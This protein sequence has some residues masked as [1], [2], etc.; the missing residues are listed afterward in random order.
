MQWPHARFRSVIIIF[1]VY[2]LFIMAVHAPFD[3]TITAN[4]TTLN[5]NTG[6]SSTSTITLTGSGGSGNV[7]LN[8][9]VSPAGL[10]CSVIP[11]TVTLGTTATATLVC[12][13]TM[14]GTFTVIVTGTSGTLSH[15]AVVTVNVQDFAITSNPSTLNP[16]VG[17]RATS[18]ISITGIN[19]FA[20]TVSL[21]VGTS[22]AGSSCSVSPAAVTLPPSPSTTTLSCTASTA[23]NYT[24]AV[25]GTSGSLSHTTSLTLRVSDFAI[26][27]GP[28][29]VTVNSG[30]TGTATVVLTSQNGYAGTVGLTVS[31]SPAGL[32]CFL[33]PSSLTLTM[34]ATSRLDCGGLVGTYTVTV[35]GSSGTLTHSAT[36]TYTVQDFTLGGS[37]ALTMNA[38]TAVTSPIVLDSVNGFTGTVTLSS[39]VS[40]A[41]G[42]TCSLAPST[43]L[44]GASATSSLSCTGS[45][46]VYTVTVTG[47]SN[48]L[49]HAITLTY[50]VEDMLVVPATNRVTVA[51][52]GSGITTII[53]VG[54]DGFSG[55][56]SLTTNISPNT[57]LTCSL[58]PTSIIL[59]NF[60]TST[61]S[62]AGD[63]GTYTV[64]VTATSGSLSHTTRLTYTVQGPTSSSSSLSL[65]YF[66]VAAALAGSGLTGTFAVRR[67]NKTTAPFDEFFNLTG[68]E[69]QP[70]AT[71]LITGDPGAGTTTLGLQLLHRQLAGGKY[72]G[73]LTYDAFPS[74][75]QLK[76]RSL[77]LDVTGSLKDGSLKILD[78]YSSLVGGDERT[79]IRDP[80]DFTEISIQVSEMI[81]R[82]KGPITLLLDSLSPI[83][84][85]AQAGT[86]L[87]FLRVLG[88]KVKNNG[89][90]FILTATK[91]SIPD[92]V[93]S[94]VEAMADIT[95]DLSLTRKG[96]MVR[97]TLSIKKMA[98]RRVSPAPAQFEIVTGKGILFKKNRIG[99]RRPSNLRSR[100]VRGELSGGHQ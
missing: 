45:A 69:F 54:L 34:T 19:G 81:Q 26:T 41:T 4:P 16:P 31:S 10:S 13:G 73:L 88:A 78:C 66:L 63:P 79:A 100:E 29:T 71:L 40:P 35:T 75:V 67:F 44:L 1:L 84:D 51:P 8:A 80:I 37:A 14:V 12:T 96:D 53:V 99:F 21:A 60:G 82:V 3:F 47:T 38:G 46:G 20:G 92:E 52:T 25:T 48:L 70:P 22:P 49:S 17:V 83:F 65:V 90:I 97:R 27:I 89:G 42:L 28:A 91:G 7:N 33:T 30:D 2:T 72:C 95:I 32:S 55:P 64:N 18:T 87:N 76:M 58:T 85:S 43:V 57:G 94:K 74:E 23:A 6:S 77:G 62:C 24:A 15:S 56:V 68:G 9:T 11:S 5:F 39:T 59:G 36:V 50:T 98:G 61:L 86:V 93:R